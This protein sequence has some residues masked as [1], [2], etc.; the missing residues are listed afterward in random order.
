MGTRLRESKL[1]Y[2]KNTIPNSRAKTLEGLNGPSFFVL[3]KNLRICRN[4]IICS[5]RP[6]WVRL[7]IK[8]LIEKVNAK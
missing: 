8:L 3:R 5:L 7:N 4:A 6:F 1:L 2:Q